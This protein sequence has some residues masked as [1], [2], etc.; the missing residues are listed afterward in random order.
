MN[1]TTAQ[2]RK[3]PKPDLA[4]IPTVAWMGEDAEGRA[5]IVWCK[6]RGQAR[7]AAAAELER[8]FREVV[9]CR[10][11]PQLDGFTGNLRRW[12]MSH[13]WRWECQKCDRPCYGQDE[14]QD[15]DPTITTV[16]DEDDHV[17]C[18]LEHCREYNAYWAMHRAIDAAILE[19]FKKLYPSVE[20]LHP[21]VNVGHNEWYGWVITYIGRVDVWEMVSV[22]QNHVWSE[23]Q[24]RLQQSG[25]EP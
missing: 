12:Q 6:T 3:K 2:S 5:A 14:D 19:D 20:V 10:R 25:A 24:R 13:G 17:F 16:I 1:T 7:Q 8:D 18:C 21:S 9:S 23:A 4:S 22:H 15:L 11:Y